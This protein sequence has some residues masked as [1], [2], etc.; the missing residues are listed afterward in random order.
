ME[1]DKMNIDKLK[2][3]LNSFLK[4]DD[5]TKIAQLLEL[6]VRNRKVTYEEAKA[7]I[8]EDIEDI[9]I[10]AYGWRMLLPVKAAKAGDWEDKMLTA[11]PGETYQAVSVVKHLAE[12]AS[13][14]G[15]WDPEIA[16]AQA[17]EDIGEPEIDKMPIL[18]ARIASQ[19][20][21]RRISGVQIKRLCTELGLGDRVDPLTSELKACGIISPKLS[22][23]TDPS[24]AGTPIYEINPCLLVGDK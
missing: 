12:N 5:A 10:L 16:I 14:S 7:V 8:G 18:I 19:V 17:F 23:L 9:L 21:G 24:R 6:V 4:G 22:S 11:Q 1:L 2:E 20:K 3:A 13:K 15:R